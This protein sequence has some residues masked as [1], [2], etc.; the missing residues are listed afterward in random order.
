MSDRRTIIAQRV[1]LDLESGAYVNLGI[2]IPTLVANYIAD[3]RDIIFHTE[4]GILGFVGLTPDDDQVDADLIDAGKQPVRLR[5]GG[6]FFDHGLSFAM[7]RGG[8]IDV[9]VLGAFQVS[10]AGALASWAD[11][12]DA[13]MNA[14]GGA[15]DLAVGAKQVFVA[16]T[17]TSAGR[18]KLVDQCSLPLTA[19]SGVS[20]VYTELGVFEPV[21]TGFRALS[22]TPGVS[23]ATV[24]EETGAR[25]FFDRMEAPVR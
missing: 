7:I 11:D 14:V 24:I 16:M 6:S 15:M 13:M 21:G 17:H 23:E 9:A 20:R 8:H 12:P 18:R 1:A 10:A 5:S 2:G 19:P 3:D 22:L 4:N 25:V